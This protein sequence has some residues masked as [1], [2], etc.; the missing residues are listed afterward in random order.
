MPLT[1]ACSVPHTFPH[2][3]QLLWSVRVFTSH[4][5]PRCMSQSAK[6]ML[7]TYPHI[8][9][10]QVTVAFAAC[11]QTVPHEPQFDVSVWVLRQTPPQS[12]WPIGHAA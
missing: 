9:P 8:P 7:H 6:P 3:P 1:Q 12:V 4:P 2:M 11:G 5:F 10:E